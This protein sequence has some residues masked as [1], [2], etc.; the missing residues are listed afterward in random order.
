M[1]H[2]FEETL[3]L[4][5]FPPTFPLATYSRDSKLNTLTAVYSSSDHP[6]FSA[7]PKTQYIIWALTPTVNFS[8]TKL[9][10]PTNDF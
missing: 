4:I 6:T 3:L 9:I 1:L 5:L 2:L 7:K 10:K 8:S